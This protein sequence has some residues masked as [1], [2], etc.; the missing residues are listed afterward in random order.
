MKRYK[1]AI[2][3][4][5]LC[6]MMVL[7][8]TVLAYDMRDYT[9]APAGTNLMIWYYKSISGV[10][11]YS[12]NK[13]TSDLDVHATL[14]ILRVVK[15]V[16]VPGT[17][18]IADPQF[19]LPFGYQ[20]ANGLNGS[21]GLGDLILCATLW[22]VNNPAEKHYFGITPYVYVPTGDYDSSRPLNLGSNRWAGQLEFSNIKGWGNWT[23]DFG[24]SVM[25]YTDN[26]RYG[27]TNQ[28]LKQDPT[29]NAQIAV[30][31][32]VN[33]NFW[34]GLGYY[35]STGGETEVEG[36]GLGK[37]CASQG[38][39]I[40]FDTAWWLTPQY[41]LLVTYKLG[42]DERNGLKTNEYGFRI[43]YAY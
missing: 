11:Y 30:T 29:Y 18:I 17:D 34:V 13:R 20:Y 31:Y 42:L 7:P 15:F 19:L 3:S 40:Q 6:L 24:A 9:A 14:G 26:N 37:S 4:L 8:G 43:M 35:F 38:Q 21:S 5:V 28:T 10:Q 25:A 33:K 1:V 36:S 32:D 23:L 22:F 39:A 2:V 41:Q 27:A 16:K 12:D